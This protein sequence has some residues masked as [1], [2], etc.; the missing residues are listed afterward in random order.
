MAHNCPVI[1]LSDSS[2]REILYFLRALNSSKMVISQSATRR[3][4]N[5]NPPPSRNAEDRYKGINLLKRRYP[6][7]Q[8][9]RRQDS[10]ISYLYV[11]GMQKSRS[12]LIAGE[13]EGMYVDM[14]K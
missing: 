10:I 5:F 12:S 9:E 7:L 4:F 1:V 2:R 13:K 3:M 11:L 8:S 14:C 6:S